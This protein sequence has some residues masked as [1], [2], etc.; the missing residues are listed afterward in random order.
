MA[1]KLSFRLGAGEY[2]GSPVKVDRKKLY[3][4]SEIV[5][6]DDAG[7][8]CQV[9]WVDQTGTLVIPRG[10]VGLGILDSRSQWV[11]R[12][13]LQAVAAD[14]S[15]AVTRTS[16]YDAPIE[17]AEKASVEDLLDLTLS[18]VY[19]LDE[20]DPGLADALGADIYGFDYYYRA[21]YSGSRAYLLANEGTVFMF[22]G[23]VNEFEWLGLEQATL[24]EPETEE[25]ED[26]DDLD[27]SFM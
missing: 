16:S 11:D 2:G 4:W 9:A 13:D 7:Q 12:S 10:G 5:A 26:S 15:P 27:F 14:G 18:A 25:S 6:L 3:G 24:V 20:A 1:R 21:G 8:E 17:L 19:Q 23:Y 22:T